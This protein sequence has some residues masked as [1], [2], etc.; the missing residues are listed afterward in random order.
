M[1]VPMQVQAVIL[2][3]VKADMP[4]RVEVVLVLEVGDGVPVRRDP[5]GHARG[6]FFHALMRA[7]V[8]SLESGGDCALLTYL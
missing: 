2:E 4:A 3:P 8:Q 6:W 5:C 7:R 1:Q